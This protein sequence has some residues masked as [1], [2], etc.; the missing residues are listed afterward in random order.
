LPASEAAGGR[1][2]EASLPVAL[3][4][5]AGAQVQPS[6]DEVRGATAPFEPRPARRVVE[7]RLC[8]SYSNLRRVC[9][10]PA[11]DSDP[12]CRQGPE[13]GS[14]GGGGR[15]RS[16]PS[17]PPPDSGDADRRC[18]ALSHGRPRLVAGKAAGLFLRPGSL[19]RLAAW[20][21]KWAST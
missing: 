3:A 9:A 13:R 12:V 15:P 10:R 17:G 16:F 6:C 20:L 5:G 18:H 7:P 14:T 11:M 21:Q 1:T 2:A 19:V 8:E 4:A